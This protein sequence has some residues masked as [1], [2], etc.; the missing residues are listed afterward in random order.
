MSCQVAPSP[1]VAGGC[2]V[3]E[4]NDLEQLADQRLAWDALLAETRQA[5]FF[6][7][8]DWL[9][10]YWQHHGA[11][12]KLRVLAVRA[13]GKTIGFL[14]L[15]EVPIDTR[16]GRVRGL[17][18]PL[19]DWGTFYGPIGPNPTATL[20][21]GLGHIART[22]RDHC[23]WDLIDLR[24]VDAARVDAGRTPRALAAKGFDCYEQ[25]WATGAMIDLARAGDWQAYW[26]SRSG[27]WRNNVRRNE[28]RLLQHGPLRFVR[29][30]PEGAA[31][32]DDDPRWD[33]YQVCEDLAS[34][35]WQADSNCGTTLTHASIQAYLRDTHAAATSVGASE[36]NLLYVGERPVAFNYCYHYRGNLFGLRMGY[37]PDFANAGPGSV[38]FCR[39]LEDSFVR[40]DSQLDLGTNYLQ[41]KRPWMT[42]EVTSYRYRHIPTG[43]SRVQL[44]RSGLALSRTLHIE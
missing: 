40:G 21:V 42:H 7:S 39:M 28:K 18:Y 30:R 9:R 6:H 3:V 19:N 20:L 24:Y 38:L 22:A 2:H 31:Y 23:D 32:G 16:L 36:I 41:C 43:W 13:G 25:P 10:V 8:L 17:C 34:R 12:G 26:A 11:D 5:T 35:S 15:V 44:I 14:P 4:I 33:Y 37:D 1:I 27:K 29:Y